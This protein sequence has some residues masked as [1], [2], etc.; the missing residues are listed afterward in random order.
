MKTMGIL[1]V[2]SGLMLAIFFVSPPPS[3]IPEGA[4]SRFALVVT[5]KT[6]LIAGVAMVVAGSVM[7]QLHH[8]KN[9][10]RKEPLV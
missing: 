9:G 4:A 1:L 2:I 7:L 5:S 8:R 6:G 10:R 3:P